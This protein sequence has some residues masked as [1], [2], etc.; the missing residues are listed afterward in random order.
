LDNYWLIFLPSVKSAGGARNIAGPRNFFLLQNIQTGSGSHPASCSLGTGVP[1]W[2]LG[3]QGMMLTTHLYLAPRLRI[4]GAISLLLCMCSWCGQGHLTLTLLSIIHTAVLCHLRWSDES[5]LSC[6]AN[7][8]VRSGSEA[9][10]EYILWYCG[11]QR[12][13]TTVYFI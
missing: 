3:A 2:G 1:S 5:K 12:S 13:L 11:M 10:V 7:N 9:P 6:S 4:S 8:L